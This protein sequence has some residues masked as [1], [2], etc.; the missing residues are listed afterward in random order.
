MPVDAEQWLTTTTQALAG[1]TL[2][3]RDCRDMVLIAMELA[4]APGFDP[5]AANATLAAAIN[6]RTSA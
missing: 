5:D 1:S 4:E 3:H 6:Q 2:S